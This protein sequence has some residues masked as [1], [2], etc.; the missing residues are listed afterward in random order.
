MRHPAFLHQ[1]ALHADLGS[2]GRNHA[3]VIGLHA[4]DRDQRIGVGGDRVG[5]DV[6]ELAQLVAAIGEA[7]IAILPLGVELDLPAE[8]A[9]EPL[10]LFDV[11]RPEG[12][13]IAREL[14]QHGHPVDV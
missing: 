3:G 8:M 1:P 13:R 5:D 10:Q 12:Q 7:R 2:N 11:R 6:F 14:F 9:R 4:A